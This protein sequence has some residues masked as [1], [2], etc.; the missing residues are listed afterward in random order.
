MALDMARKATI[1]KAKL[2][3]ADISRHYYDDLSLTIAQHPSETDTRMMV[4]LLAFALHA[5]PGLAFTRGLSTDDEADIWL[6]N[7][8]GDIELW[9]DVGQI[10]G[11]RIRKA[12]HRAREVWIYSYGGRSAQLWWQQTA[13]ALECHQ[14]LTVVDLDATSTRAMAQMAR[15]NMTLQCT[16]DNNEIYLSD[17]EQGIYVQQHTIYNRADS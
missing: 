16:I 17:G 15:R 9:I 5:Y 7:L 1:C 10:D 12:C 4:R 8:S 3:I 13:A 6:K 14:N 2:H 11:K